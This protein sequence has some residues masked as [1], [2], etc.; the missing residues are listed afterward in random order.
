MLPPPPP[1][2]SPHSVPIYLPLFFPLFH[3][4]ALR[5][6]IF[7][8]YSTHSFSQPLTLSSFTHLTSLLSPSLPL[9]L[10]PHLNT[11]LSHQKVISW[12]PLSLSYYYG[13]HSSHNICLPPSSHSY[14]LPLDLSLC[15]PFVHFPSQSLLL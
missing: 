10:T 12:L 15:F 14:S 11:F 1:S 13:Q 8:S 7:L 9:C 5:V 4:P 3:S 2:S 6:S